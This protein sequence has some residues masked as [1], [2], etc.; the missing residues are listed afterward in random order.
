MLLGT[1][2]ASASP[3]AKLIKAS[4]GGGGG[5]VGGGHFGSPGQQSWHWKEARGEPGAAQQSRLLM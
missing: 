5:K 4:R 1:K 2:R 3:A